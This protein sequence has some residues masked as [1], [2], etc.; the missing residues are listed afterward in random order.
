[1]KLSIYRFE[2]SINEGNRGIQYLDREFIGVS[3]E[4]PNNYNIRYLSRIP[5]GNYIAKKIET[6]N[7][8]LCWVLQNVPGGRTYIILNHPGNSARD[9]SGCIGIGRYPHNDFKGERGVTHTTPTCKQFWDLTKHIDELK[10]SIID[11]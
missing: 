5:A 8:G 2:H 9:F 10:V 11:A 1:M 6:D 3:I 4:C 7:H